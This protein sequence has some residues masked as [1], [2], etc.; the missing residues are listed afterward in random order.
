MDLSELRALNVK[1]Y[2]TARNY[3]METEQRKREHKNR[4]YHH[5]KLRLFD[6]QRSKNSYAFILYS[7]P[8][9]G[10]AL[11]VVMLIFSL[12]LLNLVSPFLSAPKPYVP[13]VRAM[14]VSNGKKRNA[15]DFVKNVILYGNSKINFDGFVDDEFPVEK[16]GIMQNIFSK[17]RENQFDTTCSIAVADES[18]FMDFDIEFSSPDICG[19]VA[20]RLNKNQ[21]FK[22][23]NIEQWR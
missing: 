15:S 7:V 16:E 19:I 3:A 4:L 8:W 12:M 17:L 23:L 1:I 20:L 21:Q 6:K 14:D 18:G 10:V 5:A 9:N 2:K 11:V 22:I 13:G